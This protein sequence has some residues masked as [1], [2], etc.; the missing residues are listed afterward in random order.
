[1][2]FTNFDSRHFSVTEKTAANTALES[3]ELSVSLKLANL[4]ATERQQYG[5]VNE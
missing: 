2:S 3:L 5:S 4:T 1:M